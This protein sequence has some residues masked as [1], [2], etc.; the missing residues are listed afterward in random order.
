[1]KRKIS[2]FAV[3]FHANRAFRD[4]LVET[5]SRKMIEHEQPA[6]NITDN[7]VIEHEEFLN[8]IKK[9]LY[10]GP[11]SSAVKCTKISRPL[12]DYAAEIFSESHRGHSLS[13]LNFVTVGNLTVTPCSLILAMIYLDRLNVIDPA[14]A[15]RITPSELF[16]VSMMVSTKFYC[17]YDEDIYL[18]AWA[19]SGSMSVDH[20]KQLE[21]EFLDAI[22]WKVY[23]S[24]QEFFEKLKSVEK[25]LAKR[26]G[27]ARG[28]LTYTE[29]IN[30]IPTL[31]L[32]KQILNYS[33]VLALSYTASVMTIA[34]AFFLASNINVPGNVLFRGAASSAQPSGSGDLGHPQ[35]Q[36]NCSGGLQ[37]QPV[38]S[39]LADQHSLTLEDCECSLQKAIESVQL[40]NRAYF[41]ENSKFEQHHYKADFRQFPNVH[42]GPVIVN[43]GA[44]SANWKKHFRLIYPTTLSSGNG[45]DGEG[46]G[47][48]T[49]AAANR[50]CTYDEFIPLLAPHGTGLQ[51]QQCDRAANG[52]QGTTSSG[53]IYE[54]YKRTFEMFSSFLKFL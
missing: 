16:I 11:S 40:L 42:F 18:S 33:T 6:I 24:N 19:D 14:Y 2:L 27:L 47:N 25:V 41:N 34:G 23:V 12:A 20:M 53:P 4:V 21:L 46:D 8:R 5:D 48:E 10:Y 45:E 7:K 35:Q 50:N 3:K 1:M 54:S 52:D 51:L 28:W 32:A 44:A 37:Q 43:P 26:Q 49:M 36:Q 38:S 13:R 17:G 39:D 9:T 15:R 22:G 29:L 31:A 30:F